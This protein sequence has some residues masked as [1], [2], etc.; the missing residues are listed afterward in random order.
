MI[1]GIDVGG[2]H[3][4]AVLLDNLQVRK[5]TKVLT[6]QENLIESLL[7]TADEILEGENPRALKR[8]VFSTTISTNAIVQGKIDRVG[9]AI[10]SGPGL[11]PS[12]LKIS[13]DTR[14]VSGSI[15]HRGIEVA[16]IDAEEIGRVGD[17]FRKEGIR[18]LSVVGKFS[19]RNPKQEIR[20]R[21]LLNGDFSHITLGHR[22]SGNLNFPR[23]IATAFLNAAVWETYNTFVGEILKFKKQA[24]L[25]TPVYILKADGGTFEIGHSAEFP[26]YTILSGPA[27]SIM[28]ILSLTRCAGDAVAI[29]VGGTTTDIAVFSGG[30]PLLEPLGVT[31]EGHRTLIRGLKTR[32]IGAGGD[33]LVRYKNGE[34]SIGP[35]R[36]GPA[37]AFGGRH[38]TPTDAMIVLG[39]TDIGDSR[40][41]AEAVGPLAKSMKIPIR[42]AA[43]RIF[44]E[45]C[46]LIASAAGD[47]L[48]EINNKPVYTIHEMLEGKKIRPETLYVVGG[49][50]GPMAAKLGELLGCSAVIPP[51]AE[52]ANAVGAA[53]SR[54]TTEVT[55]LADTEKKIMTIAEEGLQTGIPG[56]FS[57]E[58]AVEVCREK[59]RER[60]LL[61]G[62][63][64]EDIE[65]EIVEDLE[66]NMVRGYSRTGKN[67]RLKAQIK[68]GLIAGFSGTDKT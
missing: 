64:D 67:I 58:D 16:P 25:E 22:M 28:G 15:N 37:A 46:R 45:T 65:M 8:I 24:R 30:V 13:E 38:P 61:I 6:I 57:R 49:P 54:N 21:D 55:L 12:L 42:E 20:I 23:R 10:A 44:R 34:I 50:A 19:T 2:T 41:A 17:H 32:S 35:E 31:I 36:D 33:S 40:K 51:H 66:F 59:L 14:F 11:P 56:N 7:G 3:T 63:A 9:L 48:D 18:Y 5:K 60:A 1:L 53:L 68:P 29:D 47:M 39:L 4:D 43:E 27:A 62:A 26:V 52:V